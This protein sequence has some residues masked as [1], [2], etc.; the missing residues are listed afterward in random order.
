LSACVPPDA[1]SRRSGTRKL[2]LAKHH[3][4]DYQK[5]RS[6]DANGNVKLLIAAL[7][8]IQQR[9][10][11]CHSLVDQWLRLSVQSH[12]IDPSAKSSTIAAMNDTTASE[13]RMSVFISAPP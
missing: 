1:R 10:A 3:E 7:L 2:A 8:L 12:R 9:R 13:S 11:D 5:R 6:E 4:D